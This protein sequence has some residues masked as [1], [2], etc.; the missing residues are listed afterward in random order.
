MFSDKSDFTKQPETSKL[1]RLKQKLSPTMPKLSFPGLL[2]WFFWGVSVKK[3]LLLGEFTFI[4]LY[5]FKLSGTS[6]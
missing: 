4:V 3:V 5:N 6:V 2:G 1:N